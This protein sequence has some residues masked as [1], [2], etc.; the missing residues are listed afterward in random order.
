MSG[1]AHVLPD[2]T[3][4]VAVPPPLSAPAVVMLLTMKT[5]VPSCQTP[6]RP[7]K[8]MLMTS[9]MVKMAEYCT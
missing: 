9:G 1:D 7:V 6:A 4:S 5:P 8:P 3:V 2:D